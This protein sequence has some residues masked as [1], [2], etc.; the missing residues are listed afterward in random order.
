M[1]QTRSEG[2]TYIYLVRHG[3][4]EGNVRGIIQGHADFPLT[5]NGKTQA[6]KLAAQLR[7][8]RFAAVYAS[9]L[10][11]AKE[12]AA[13][14]ATEKKLAVQTTK[15]LREKSFGTFD[16]DATVEGQRELLRLLQEHEK[17]VDEQRFRTKVREDIETDE[18]VVARF[19]LFLREV[20]FAHQNEHVLVVSHSGMLRSIL[21]HLGY[22]TYSQLRHGS[23]PNT[24]YIVL[25][26]DGIEFFVESTFG[27]TRISQD[28]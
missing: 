22:A 6:S 24:S 9:D 10:S 5:A 15:L 23:I 25:K 12:T 11:R 13:I 16:T 26:T 14:V 28:L 1:T 8:T 4:S 19:I 7:S 2:Y 27:I 3:E 20:A 18:E 21:V 17:L